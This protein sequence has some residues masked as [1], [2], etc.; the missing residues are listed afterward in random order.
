[1]KD[2]F[3]H[4]PYP[5]SIYSLPSL[6]AWG[7]GF[8]Q[9][10]FAREGDNVLLAMEEEWDEGGKYLLLP[11]STDIWPPTALYELTRRT[12]EARICFTPA[13][14]FHVV[15]ENSVWP[16]FEIH[17]QHVYADYVYLTSDL[18]ELKGNRYAGKRNLI[19][20]FERQFAPGRVE[21]QPLTSRNRDECLAFLEEWCE[22][23]NCRGEG[24]EKQMLCEKRAITCALETMEEMSWRGIQIR[25]DGRIC[26]FAMMSPL[27]PEMGVL[28]FEKAF[29]HIKGLYQYLDRECARRLFYDRKYIN[30]ESDMGIETLAVSKRSYEP[31]AMIRSF[32]LTAW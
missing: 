21:V 16:W 14:Y 27:T 5:L 2:L 13:D 4:Q 17:E 1:L 19:H 10:Y 15:G 29:A 23:R 25:I 20:Q 28:N 18:A 9:A 8:Y 12:G 22:E 3:H 32:C 11:I 24:A 31:I 6:I 7:E 26:A 30:K